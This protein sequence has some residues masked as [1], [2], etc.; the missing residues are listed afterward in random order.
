MFSPLTQQL[1]NRH[2]SSGPKISGPKMARPPKIPKFGGPKAGM[3]EVRPF[4]RPFATGL[5]P[6]AL[7]PNIKM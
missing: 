5:R 7:M 3:P 4:Q 6:T 1:L 2:M